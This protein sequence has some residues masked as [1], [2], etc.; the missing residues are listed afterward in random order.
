M[1]FTLFGYPKTG[2]TTL[3][4][5]LTGAGIEVKAYSEGNKE[6]NL[7]TVPI[8]DNRLDRLAAIYPDKK[9][10][11]AS[12]DYIDLAGMSFGEVKNSSYLSHLRQ[13][14]GLA[15]VI[16]AFRD[17]QIPSS[18]NGIDAGRD[19]RAM[20]EELILADLLT[21]EARLEK[22][23][24]DLQR[25][26]NTEGKKELELMEMLR[27][28]LEKG[29]ALRETSL[30]HQEEKLLSGF[31]FLSRK[32]VLH[33]VNVDEA[34]INLI[35]N[36]GSQFSGTGPGTAVMAFCGAV[37]SEILELPEEE[38]ELFLKEYGLSELSSS[39]FLRA[40]Y[41]LLNILTFYTIGDKEVKAWTIEKGASAQKA[42]GSIHTDME[43]GFIRAE[44]IPAEEL[45]RRGSMQ[46]AKEHGL[47][48]LEGRE[49]P[50]RDGDILYIRH[51]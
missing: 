49:Y 23:A 19:I 42:A 40:S 20:E 35:D 33:V 31:T 25:A 51:S 10:K 26:P 2:K 43:K 11:S 1:K 46:A 8:P 47:V 32:P 22:L 36:P 29:E 13:S 9:K 50:V 44:V 28:A 16:R 30:S 38:K 41:T 39:K 45:F 21:V 6:P 5:L 24:K 14:D 27:Q 4:N 3:F 17:E 15:H 34:D 48:R 7:R 12:V 18:K 37:E